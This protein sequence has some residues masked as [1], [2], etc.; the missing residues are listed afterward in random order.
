[1][2]QNVIKSVQ[3]N[4]EAMNATVIQVLLLMMT[5][6]CVKVQSPDYITFFY[7]FCF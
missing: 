6:I 7:E 2:I 5:P 3:T 1:M 4:L